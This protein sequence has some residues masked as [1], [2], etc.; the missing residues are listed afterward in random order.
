MRR[1]KQRAI[2]KFGNRVLPGGDMYEQ[3]EKFF[4][5]AEKRTPD[6]IEEWLK[7]MPCQVLRLDGTKTIQENVDTIKSLLLREKG[8]RVSGG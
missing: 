1:I 8:D 6:K 3:E 4:A 7:T 5:Y 2:E